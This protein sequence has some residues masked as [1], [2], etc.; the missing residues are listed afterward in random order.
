M[1]PTRAAT[2]ATPTARAPL[3]Q[4][5]GVPLAVILLVVGPGP[6]ALST[7]AVARELVSAG[8]E[9]EVVFEPRAELFVGPAAFAPTAPVVEAPT[10]PPEAVVF[11]P[12]G[13]PTLARLARGLGGAESF[14]HA[15][16]GVPVVVAL[17]LD[18]GTAG[19]PVVREN[20]SL[21]QGDGVRILGGAGEMGSPA[22]VAGAL[23]NAMGGPLS[24][25]PELDQEPSGLQRVHVRLYVAQHGGDGRR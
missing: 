8:H 2:G 22:G 16:S 15:T 4:N 13:A 5:P 11:A 1:T 14:S 10:A 21:L 6:G 12:A 23:L 18:E 3:K 20:A 19:H 9:V 25:K 17:E 7:P 24:G